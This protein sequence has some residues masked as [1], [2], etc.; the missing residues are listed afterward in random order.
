MKRWDLYFNAVW[1]GRFCWNCIPL[2]EMQDHDHVLMVETQ[3]PCYCK[4]R[5]EVHRIEQMQDTASVRD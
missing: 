1:R 3:L 4:M 2:Q 5:L